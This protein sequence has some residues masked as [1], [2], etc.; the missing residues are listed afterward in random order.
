MVYNSNVRFICF[1]HLH[2]GVLAA[3][4]ND[5]TIIA[6][7]ATPDNEKSMTVVLTP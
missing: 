5:R 6:L 3:S 1:V 4:V 7:S 2:C